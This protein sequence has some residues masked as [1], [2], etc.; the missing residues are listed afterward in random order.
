MRAALIFAA[1]AGCSSIV[2]MDADRVAQCEKG[3]GCA[4]VSQAEMSAM[5]RQAYQRGAR[6]AMQSATDMLDSHGCRRGMT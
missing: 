1:L 2:P 3:G 6:Q 4:L 5:L